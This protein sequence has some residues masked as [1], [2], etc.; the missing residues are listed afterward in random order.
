MIDLKKYTFFSPGKKYKRESRIAPKKI[1]GSMGYWVYGNKV[2]FISSKKES[3]G[4]IVESRELTQLKKA[5]FEI[6]WKNSKP[7][8][9]TYT[10]VD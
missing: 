7:I 8:K 3:F 1:E 6:L 5:E 9:V 4:F 10:R 2:A